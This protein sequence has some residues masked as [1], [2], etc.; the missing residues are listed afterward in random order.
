MKQSHTE[1]TPGG[2]E[3]Y[4]AWKEGSVSRISMSLLAEVRWWRAH[5]HVP[6]AEL[7]LHTSAMNVQ[8]EN[9]SR[10]WTHLESSPTALQLC[11]SSQV[12]PSPTLSLSFLFS[13]IEIGISPSEVLCAQCIKYMK[14]PAQ[15]PIQQISIGESL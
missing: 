13:E 4:A 11:D 9:P 1:T 6:H 7:D 14:H 8:R 15:G 3:Y 5:G 10:K 12:P 2:G